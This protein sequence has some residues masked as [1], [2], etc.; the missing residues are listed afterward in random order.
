MI[1]IGI[2]TTCGGITNEE[3]YKKMKYLKE[4]M[5]M[6]ILYDHGFGYISM[7]YGIIIRSNGS[8]AIIGTQMEVDD[9]GINP[10]EF[11]SF[12]DIIQS[13]LD[14]NERLVEFRLLNMVEIDKYHLDV[15]RINTGMIP[16][17]DIY[18]LRDRDAYCIE[19]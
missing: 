5:K 19:N 10:S 3:R 18:I 6:D 11:S 2:Q 1:Y 7:L 9:F 16:H 4:Q 14:E 15:V 17:Q 13:D 8:M 12:A